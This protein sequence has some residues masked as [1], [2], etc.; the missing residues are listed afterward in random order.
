MT[1][2]LIHALAIMGAVALASGDAPAADWPTFRGDSR[3]SGISAEKLQAPLSA[4]W[5]FTPLDPPSHAWG[6]PQPKPIEG[7]LERPRLRFDD[8]FHVAAVGGRVFFGSSADGMVYCLDARTGRIDWRFHTDGPVR[9]APTV[10]KGKVYV[11]SDDG[12]V[13]CIDALWPVRTSVVVDKGVAYFGAGVFPAEGLY[14]YAVDADDGKLIW[15]NDSYGAGGTGQIS[16]QGYMLVSGDRLF[17]PSGR[18]MPA[19][20]DRKT[21]AFLFHRDFSWRQVGLFGGTECVLAEGMLFTGT[22][23]FVAASQQTGGLVMVE[24]L[25]VHVPSKGSRR[26]AFEGDTVHLL[27]GT[28][29]AAYDKDAWL[30]ARRQISR[31]AMQSVGL[32][33]QRRRLKSRRDAASQKALA[34]VNRRLGKL[35]AERRD[36]VGKL[37]GP[38]RWVMACRFSESML[39]T[40]EIVF[41]GGAGK[42]VGMDKS[43]G[44]EV[45]SAK[46]D[47]KA[48][49]L[50]AADGRLLVSTDTGTIYSFSPGPAR[51]SRGAAPK[52]ASRPFGKAPTGAFYSR[53]A[54]AIVRDT[55][56]KRGYALILGSASLAADSQPGRLAYELARRTDLTIHVVEP[57]AARVAAARKA[58]TAG[59]VYGSRVVVMQG[60]LSKPPLPDYFAN[61]IVVAPSLFAGKT[62]TEPS[63]LL[64]LLK[65]CGGVAVV[66]QSPRAALFAASPATV[67]PWVDR[68]RG[69]LKDLGEKGTKVES[70]KSWTV[71]ARG[72][73]SGAG[74]WTHQYG[75]AGNTAS[76]DDRLVKGPIGILWYGE[77]GPG[78]MPSRHASNSAPLAVNGRMF[79]E[80]ENVIMAYDAYNGLR[81]WEREMPGAMR[82]GMQ[83]GV[84]NFAADDDSL[85]VAVADRCHRLDAATGRTLKTY[86]IPP[87][88][89]DQAPPRRW[90]YLAVV[91]G[92]IYGSVH[93]RQLDNRGRERPWSPAHAESV[94]AVDVET[95]KLTWSF[96]SKLIDMPTICVGGG[97]VFLVDRAVT[98]E[99]RAA[100]LKGVD[101]KLRVDARGR[102]I[103]PDVR[104]VVRLD[105]RSG[106]VLWSKPQYLSDCVKVSRGGGDLTAMVAHNVLLLCGQPWNGHFW[107][108]FFA[109]EF[110]RRSLIAL[111]ADTGRPLWS[112]RKGYRSRPLIVGDTIIAEPWAHDL[113]TGSEKMRA[114]PVTGAQAKWQMSRPGH[115]CGNIAGCLNALFFRS[116]TTAYYDLGGDYGTAHFGAQRP[117]CW[118]NCI[119]ANGLVIMPE[120]SSGCICPFSL[121]CTIVFAPRKANRV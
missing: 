120:A 84:S 7:A 35:G 30:A 49:G 56:V 39:V 72:P 86:A 100:C 16:P 113:Q 60:A 59:G 96:D 89:G 76:S 119:P 73:L 64:R 85:Y 37:A 117:G 93:E 46:V 94:F 5:V 50:A 104:R 31:I 112:G 18:S 116:G 10:A 4:A 23:Q 29:A 68:F 88:K 98:A 82:L 17:L 45:W 20:F 110:S 38:T 80:G 91:D 51:R 28:K 74:G 6:D 118:I 9:L 114:H 83:R 77:P 14:L 107:K 111:A 32:L 12:N 58:L 65:P 24:G 21:G 99:Q 22:E 115:H 25:P 54:D 66:G 57:D 95:G 69:V 27:D 2:R 79:V 70:K 48:R 34:D 8:A 97:G 102:P 106:D 92:L 33:G 101:H 108:E 42:V 19:A 105:A 109:G 47:G 53:T 13:Y 121:H 63:E 71:I 1:H 40:R 67:K 61:L 26:L 3:R 90:G 81:L 36:A 75:N 43:T 11:G 15:K 87:A 78:R 52:V 44:A 62:P 55:G 41:A 103:P